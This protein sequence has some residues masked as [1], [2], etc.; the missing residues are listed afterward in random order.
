M[1]E[2]KAFIRP[3]KAKEVCKALSA[4]QFLKQQKS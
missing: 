4:S 1:K 3:F 2:I